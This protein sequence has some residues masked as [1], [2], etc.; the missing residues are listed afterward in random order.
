MLFSFF[1]LPFSPRRGGRVTRYLQCA[2]KLLSRHVASEG[3]TWLDTHGDA[4]DNCCC[5]CCCCWTGAVDNPCCTRT[6]IILRGKTTP[7]IFAFAHRNTRTILTRCTPPPP[8][9]L[10]RVLGKH[11]QRVRG[12]E[13][14]LHQVP[15]ATRYHEL[16]S[17]AS[18]REGRQR[19]YS[20]AHSRGVRVLLTRIEGRGT[21]VSRNVQSRTD[22]KPKL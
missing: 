4:W 8:P 5:C 1:F 17:S 10:P 18:P 11:R 13:D 16:L 6:A 19:A 3:K 15:S 21:S 2:R 12:T 7:R 20:N 22:A 9:P 14:V